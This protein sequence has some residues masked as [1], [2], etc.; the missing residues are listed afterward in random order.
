MSSS[1]CSTPDNAE[2]PRKYRAVLAAA[3]ELF[4]HQGY[5][6]VSMDAVAKAAGVSKAT[7]YA[8]LPGK[9]ALLEAVVADRCAQMAEQV[10]ALAV[11]DVPLAESLRLLAD[12]WLRFLLDPR[13]LRM[14]RM[15]IAESPR[16]PDLARRFFEAGPARGAAF[17][18]GWITEEQ[19]LGR[20][21]PELDPKVTTGHVSSLIRGD[22]FNR[23]V[24]GIEQ[25][26]EER[27]AGA[28]AATVE[29][30]LRAFAVEPQPAG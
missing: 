22:L 2:V 7:L 9:E 12:S 23:V 1:L 25:P 18:T 8:Y 20:F 6:A 19:R 24:L 15:V 17:I 5:A 3:G 16:F 28:V 29:V 13:S 21:R 11:H 14:Y 30:L 4:M 26:G 10:G 27:I